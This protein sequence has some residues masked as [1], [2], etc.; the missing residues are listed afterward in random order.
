MPGQKKLLNV[1]ISILQIAKCMYFNI[2]KLH[3]DCKI[4]KVLHKMILSFLELKED[5]I[6]VECY[7]CESIAS[8]YDVS[9]SYRVGLEKIE[10]CIKSKEHKN[11][12][13][14]ILTK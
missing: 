1:C 13:K 10:E 6:D 11:M 14:D 5:E 3:L 12:M 4:G 7:K 9:D 2:T 8:S